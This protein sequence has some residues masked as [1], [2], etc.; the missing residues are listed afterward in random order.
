MKSLLIWECSK[1]SV[2]EGK[3]LTQGEAGALGSG[4][5]GKALCTEFEE[6]QL[7]CGP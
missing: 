7:S 2:D 3:Y 1:H 5:D 6:F 4:Q